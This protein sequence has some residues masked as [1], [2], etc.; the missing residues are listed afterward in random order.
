MPFTLPVKVTYFKAQYYTPG[1]VMPVRAI[2]NHRMVGTVA[3]TRSYFQHPNRPVSTHFGIGIIGGKIVID[4]YVPLDDTAFGNGNYAASGVW[5]DWGYPLNNINAQTIN[6]EHQDHGDPAGTGV[7]SESIQQ[8]SI[9]LQALLLRGSTAE[10]R[11]AGIVLRDYTRNAPILQKQLRGITP[12][13]R[14]I[15]THHDIA[16]NLKPSCWMPWSKDRIGF[17]RTKYIAGINA[18]IQSPKEDELQ[19]YTWDAKTAILG[20]LTVKDDA[21]HYYLRLLDGTLHGPMTPPFAKRAFGPVKLL[22]GINGDTDDRKIGWLVPEEVAFI[23]AVDSVVVPD[24]VTSPPANTAAI[25]K[26]LR[27]LADRISVGVIK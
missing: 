27:S 16:G 5:D 18:L 25:V 24:P 17:P 19:S 10:W 23:L 8:A 6:I 9:A 7:V 20:N 22:K 11:A 13:P 1:R 14:T 4:Q 26:E 2:V 15:I 12:G 21:P 3:G